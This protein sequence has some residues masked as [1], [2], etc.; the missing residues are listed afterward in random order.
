MVQLHGQE[1]R[2][3]LNVTKDD[4]LNGLKQLMINKVFGDWGPEQRQ[5]WQANE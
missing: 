2:L 4:T 5:T 1:I 3:D